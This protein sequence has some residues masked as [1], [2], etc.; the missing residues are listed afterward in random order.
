MYVKRN[1][2]AHSFNHCCSVKVVSTTYS[3]CVSVA[4]GTQREMHMRHTAICGLSGSTTFFSHYLINGTN[5]EKA[6]LNI[7]ICVDFFYNIC[8]KHFSF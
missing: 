2:E 8:L 3:E 4:L 1:T 5:F 7:K 6:P